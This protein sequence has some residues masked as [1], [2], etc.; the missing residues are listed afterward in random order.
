MSLLAS[1]TIRKD[2]AGCQSA[3]L[4]ERQLAG[5]VEIPVCSSQG[6]FDSPD[7]QANTRDRFEA[8]LARLN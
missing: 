2:T 6:G 5:L 4:V 8:E 3:L 7:V 1:Q